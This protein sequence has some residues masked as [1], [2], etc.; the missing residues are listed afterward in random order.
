MA[1]D[2]KPKIDLKARLGKT[3]VHQASVPPH[4][5][6]AAPVPAPS[7]GAPPAMGGSVRPQTGVSVRPPPGFVKPAAPVALDPSNPLAAVAAPGRPQAIGAAAAISA[8]PAAPAPLPQPQRIEVDEQA[9][10]QARK[11][12]LKQG[13]VAGSVGAVVLAIVG[14]IAG[15]ASEASKSHAKSVKDAQSLAEDV[16]KSR[17]QLKTLAEK[18]EAGRDSLLKERKFPDTLA[19]DLGGLNIDFDGSKLAGVRFSGYKAETTTKLIEYI[20]AVQG[21]NDRKT[22]LASVLSRLQKPVTE[23]LTPGKPASISHVVILGNQDPSGNPFGVLAPL[24]K[25]I[26]VANP[27]QISLPAELTATDPIRKANVKLPKY[28]GGALDKDKGAIAYIA[29]A[30]IEA[31][32]PSESSGAIAQLAGQFSLL[33]TAIRGDQTAQSADI[34]TE[35]KPGLLEVADKLGDALKKVE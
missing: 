17:E 35:T 21:V 11:G 13:I 24:T 32:F 4:A 10:Q 23:Q 29:P 34:V 14:Y 31:A 1:E 18:V 27:S 16:G 5:G 30:S 8:A 19:R 33:I 12:G 20:T 15:G 25:A 22:S 9:V 6:G 2:K 28:T 3:G 7:S 26:E